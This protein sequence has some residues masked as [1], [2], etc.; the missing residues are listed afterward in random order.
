MYCSDTDFRTPP[1]TNTLWKKTSFTLVLKEASSLKPLLS[2]QDV[3][4]KWILNKLKNHKLKHLSFW[5]A[6]VRGVVLVYFIIKR[7]FLLTMHF[8]P[9]WQVVTWVNTK[10]FVLTH[11]DRETHWQ[12]N[13][14]YHNT[15]GLTMQWMSIHSCFTLVSMPS[16]LVHRR[17][18]RRVEFPQILSL[19]QCYLGI[20]TMEIKCCSWCGWAKADMLPLRWKLTLRFSWK[21]PA[22]WQTAQPRDSKVFRE[23]I[24]MWSHS[25]LASTLFDQCL[26]Y[27]VKFTQKSCFRLKMSIFD[28]S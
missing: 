9:L 26:L 8:L 5:A 12:G 17:G 27:N 7:H 4:V 2:K 1:T 15:R 14:L 24:I 21:N 6:S 11:I 3:N 10:F 22:G 20:T 18:F 23:P 13:R 28:T 19:F 16:C 25:S